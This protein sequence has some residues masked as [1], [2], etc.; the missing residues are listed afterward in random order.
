MKILP[1]ED[2]PLLLVAMKH[3]LEAE[4]GD[5][6]SVISDLCLRGSRIEDL[7]LDFTLPGY[8]EY[9]LR[10][11]DDIVPSN[12]LYIPYLTILLVLVH[13]CWCRVLFSVLLQVD[14]NSLEDYISLVVDATVKR[15]VARQ[16]EAF[17]SGF[18]QVSSFTDSPLC[19]F[20]FLLASKSYGRSGFFWFILHNLLNNRF[21]LSL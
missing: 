2:E 3:Y 12:K 14:I 13:C 10:P 17:R 8:P 21:I 1:I 18:N 11:G 16:I 5:N 15:G 6:S 4:G 7:C 20:L 19:L 9:I